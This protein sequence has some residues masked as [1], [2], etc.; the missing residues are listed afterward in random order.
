M[1]PRPTAP[2][3]KVLRALA[4]AGPVLFTLDWIL[5]GWSHPGY[6]FRRETISALS[7]HNATGWPTMAAGQVVL[8]ASFVAVA[9]AGLRA[10]GRRGAPTAAL[11]V[12][13]ALGTI[14]ATV[15][16]TICTTTNAAWCT[17]LPGTAYPHQQWAHGIGTGIAFAS[18]L[19]ACLACAVATWGVDGLRD[20]AVVC[21]VALG[22]A[23]PSVVWFLRNVDT[24]WH[25]LSEKLFL[26]S[27]ASFV[28]FAGWRL[29]SIPAGREPQEET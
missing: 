1:T 17:P 21:L 18:L 19:L 22:I 10:L 15:F 2:P 7:A 8:A 14:Q 6:H 9:V 12:L 25:G 24:T 4:L 28:A 26:T 5:L 13:A 29:T 27:L 20:L 16:R 3:V 23:L 11:L